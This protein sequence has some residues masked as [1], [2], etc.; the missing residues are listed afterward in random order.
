MSKE[1]NGR[2]ERERRREGI[3]T[4][5]DGNSEEILWEGGVESRE[6]ERKVSKEG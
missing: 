4:T 3:R 6:G 5:R 2:R 1:R